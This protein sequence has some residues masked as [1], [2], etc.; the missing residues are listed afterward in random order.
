MDNYT[1]IHIIILPI[2]TIIQY[3]YTRIHII[4]WITNNYMINYTNNYLDNYPQEIYAK[5]SIIFTLLECAEF[6][7]CLLSN[8]VCVDVRVC[9]GYGCHVYHHWAELNVIHAL[10]GT[11]R[12][13]HP[14]ETTMDNAHW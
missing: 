13:I 12:G 5:L 10:C 3:N 2:Q 11:E 1:V 9:G 6:V 8:L 7:V 14:A 4:I